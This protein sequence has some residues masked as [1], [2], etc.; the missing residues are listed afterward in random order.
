LRTADD[1]SG[2]PSRQELEAAHC[3]EADDRVPGRPEMTAFRQTSRYRQAR[4]REANGHPIGTQ[5]IAPRPGGPPA[6][7]VGSRLPL[8]YAKETG[9]AFLTAAARAAAL[10]RTSV[11]EPHQ[12]FDHQRFWADLLWSPALALNLFGDLAGDL[13][14]ADKAVH[15]WW[16]DTPGTV[17]DVRFTHSPGRFDPSFLNSLRSF[18]AAF[19]VD[20]GD[21][22]KGVVAVDVNYHERAKAEIPKPG[23]LPRCREVAER[24]GVFRPGATKAV[25][26]R[27][28]LALTWL[29]HLLL[30]SMLQHP[31]G[32]WSWG[33]YVVVHPTGNTD[34]ADICRRY[35]ELLGDHSTFAVATI[36]ELLD[37][38]ALPP[39]TVAALRA[40][41]VG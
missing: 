20:I 25:E 21:G 36:E 34:V 24:S 3:W 17:T 35:Q 19:A 30:L 28:D 27:S 16:P 18:D 13:R 9:T 33:R 1:V 26:G 31:S 11:A 14:L 38:R 40:R 29:E 8:D 10:A 39:R 7:P 12:S 32:E 2:P 41:Y 15:A 22:K 23:N 37:A 5:P 6:R 4:W